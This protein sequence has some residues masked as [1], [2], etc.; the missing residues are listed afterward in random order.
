MK[1]VVLILA[2]LTL[3]APLLAQEACG[4]MHR[5]TWE[6]TLA[7]WRQQFPKRM[8]LEARG[9][10]GQNM[11]VDLLKITDATVPATDKPRPTGWM[12]PAEVQK[13]YAMAK[14]DAMPATFTDVAYGTHFRQTLDVWLAQSNHPAPVV[15]YI[16]GG[17]WNAQDKTDIH[18]HLDVRAFL[19]AGISVASINYRFLADATAAKVTPPL[20]WPLQDAARAL[21]FLRSKAGE[22]H[23]DKTRIAATGVS[24]GGCSSLWLAMHDDM[25]DPQ[26]TDP[27]ARESTRV[28]FTATK[29]PQVSF[30]PQ[31]LVEWIPNSEYG[32]HA[33]GYPLSKSRKETFPL[34][35]ANRAQHLA[36]IQR[37]SPIAH[38][39]ADD[40]P[41]FI[42][43][44]KDDKPPV[45]GQPQ[46]DPSHSV[47]HALM[48]QEVLQPLGVPCAVHYPQDGKPATTLQEL[49][50]QHLQPDQP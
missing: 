19:A 13:K 25:A 2:W 28:L 47:L 7:H 27:I 3:L 8:V 45:K 16:H 46:T 31:Q 11:P 4:P 35:L 18:Q 39:S 48:L 22:W 37:W 12:P 43:Y 40:P 42:L 10:S 33:F 9:M 34:F 49:L 15:F 30:D 14:P 1:H 17:G 23:L 36:D 6:G 29:A 50:Q 38:A 26:S 20:Q 5:L 44:T 24:A 21:Q 41:A 32:G